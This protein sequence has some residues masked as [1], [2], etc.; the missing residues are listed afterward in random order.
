MVLVAAAA[1]VLLE[2]KVW[3]VTKGVMASVDRLIE[4]IGME[5]LLNCIIV[6]EGVRG[7]MLL[8]YIDYG[9][10][11]AS[12]PKSA[13]K[14][15]AIAKQF[16]ELKQSDLDWGMLISKRGYTM[17]DFPTD[18]DL[19]DVLGYPCAGDYEYTLAH[20]GTI[21]TYG[22]GLNAYLRSEPRNP[23]QLLVN[24]CRTKSAEGVMTR[25]AV[26]AE[27]AL[28]ASPLVGGL[29]DRVECIIHVSIPAGALL[30]KLM[31]GGMF[32]AE[33]TD[34]FRNYIFN[35]GFIT[36]RLMN[37]P[38]VFTNQAHRSVAMVL[39]SYYIDNPLEP[40]F[41]LQRH[42]EMAAVETAS[43][44]WE[45]NLIRILEASKVGGAERR[46]G[47]KRKTLRARARK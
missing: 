26:A 43:D 35:L 23:I 40:F 19:G 38:F 39:L 13:R 22:I 14:L 2:N 21:V 12:D 9:E 33:E 18:K 24:V 11:A 7:A 32:S 16:P 4:T 15:A 47:S 34:E 8:Q 17:A 31:A 5:E 1:A 3:S 25:M 37:Y 20:H 46:G 44:K 45:T 41:P 10:K 6:Q 27:R 30:D 42:R 28:R 36:D 29:I